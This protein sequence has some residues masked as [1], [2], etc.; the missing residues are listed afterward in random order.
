MQSPL[1][2]VVLLDASAGALQTQGGTNLA[3]AV[4]AP[5]RQHRIF[6]TLETLHGPDLYAAAKWA[7]QRI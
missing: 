6:A 2:V 7:A 1:R 4:A 3:N 5:F